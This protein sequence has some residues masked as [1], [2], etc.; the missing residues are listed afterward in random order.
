MDG[1]GCNAQFSREQK[2]RF[3]DAKAF[4]ALERLQQ[5]T[6]LRLAQLTNLSACPFCEF[7][8]ICPPVSIDK[9]FRCHNPECERITC[10]LCKLDSH[11]PLTCQ[12]SK[13]ESGI[14][15]R[16][17]V[18]EARTLALLRTCPKCQVKILK[19]DG[20]NKVV[21]T[22]GGM[23]CDFCG[24]DISGTGYVHFDGGTGLTGKKCP[25]YDNFHIRR[26]KDVE[27]AEAEA[28]EK[29]RRENPSI[30]VED[31]KMNFAEA[32]KSPPSRQAYPQHP[33]LGRHPHLVPPLHNHNHVIPLGMPAPH[34]QFPGLRNPEHAGRAYPA[35]HIARIRQDRGFAALER[36]NVMQQLDLYRLHFEQN[37][38]P[39]FGQHVAEEVLRSFEPGQDHRNAEAQAEQRELLRRRH[40]AMLQFQRPPHQEPMMER[41]NPVVHA[42]QPETF[43]HDVQRRRHPQ[44]AE[45]HQRR[46]RQKDRPELEAMQN[47]NGAGRQ[48]L[49]A[50]TDFHDRLR[51]AQ[52]TA[53]QH[54]HAHMVRNQRPQEL[55]PVDE[56][57]HWLDDADDEGT[58]DVPHRPV[59]ARRRKRNDPGPARR[60]T[61]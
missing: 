57:L 10:R 6:E 3:L 22:C 39:H 61:H 12:E 44:P 30:D 47:P 52:M 37:R 31:L 32:T 8:A 11:L 41:V 60:E 18:E 50:Q 1:S 4:E 13:K 20:C 16:H 58:F 14:N 27:K 34:L 56:F 35:E 2:Q 59:A 7:A 19:D 55:L 46:E 49:E 28:Q 24:K 33:A 21:C 36:E 42:A 40:N 23:L 5:Q 26:S 9:E 48:A 45:Q 53:V 17:V 25:T 43:L 51:D 54:R 38:P 29:I 15:E